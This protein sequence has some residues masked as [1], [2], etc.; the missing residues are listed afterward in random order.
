[1]K[2]ALLVK[3]NQKQ[4]QRKE[5]ALFNLEQQIYSKAEQMFELLKNHRWQKQDGKISFYDVAQVKQFN[6]LYQD[7]LRINAKIEKIKSQNAQTLQQD[8]ASPR[9]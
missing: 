8:V 3:I 7:V 2:A 1:M 9:Q 6:Q 4:D 5:Y